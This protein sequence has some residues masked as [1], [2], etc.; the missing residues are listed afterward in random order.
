[1]NILLD[2]LPEYVTIDG[3]DYFIDTDFRTFII[4]EMLLSRSDD[5]RATVEA[6]LGLFYTEEIPLD[7]SA[8]LHAI[9]DIYRCGQPEEKTKKPQK[10]GNV[11]LRPKMIYDYEFDAPYIYGAFLSQYNIDLNEIEYL[12][13]WKFQ[14]LFRSLNSSNK[15]VEIMGYRAVDLGQIKDTKE[16]ARIAKLQQIYAIPSNMTTEEKVA[17]AGAAF[18][19]GFF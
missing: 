3:K 13:W 7:H 15:I 2:E 9:L 4:Y 10:N 17:Q 19:G 16:Q 12:H 8:A 18:G 5:D 14:A 1:M 11:F 6:I